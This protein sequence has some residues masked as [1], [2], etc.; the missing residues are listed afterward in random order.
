MTDR[1]SRPPGLIGSPA[2]VALAKEGDSAW[3]Y[4]IQADAT[5]NDRGLWVSEFSEPHRP[6]HFSTSLR[7]FLLH[8]PVYRIRRGSRRTPIAM[9]TSSTR[10]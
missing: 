4:G 8:T 5:L 1:I 7:R 10:V 9:T 6:R 2:R 3:N